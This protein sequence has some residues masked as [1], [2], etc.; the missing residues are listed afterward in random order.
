[1]VDLKKFTKK[2]FAYKTTMSFGPKYKFGVEVPRSVK[3]A[4]PLDSHNGNSLWKKAIG[5]ELGSIME[6]NTFRLPERDEDITGFQKIPYHF[7]FDVK[8]DLRR[9]ARLVAGGNLTS[10][11]VDDIYSGVVGISNVRLLF[12]LAAINKLEV[13]AADVGNAYLYASNREKVYIIAGPEFGED[14]SGKK[15][16][17]AKCLYGLKTAAARFHEHLSATL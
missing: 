1:M 2:V 5:K 6:Y 3:H 4:I 15:L 8:H 11:P 17:I 10:N 16:V 13:K 9:K 12:L 7:V 14:Y